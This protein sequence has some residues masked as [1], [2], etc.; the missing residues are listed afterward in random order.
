MVDE[1]GESDGMEDE[2]GLD[3]PID[4]IVLEEE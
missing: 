3:S 4:D 1:E 2:E